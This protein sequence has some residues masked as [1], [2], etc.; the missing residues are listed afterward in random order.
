MNVINEFEAA[1]QKFAIEAPELES[2][3]IRLQIQRYCVLLWHKNQ[4]LNLTRHC[5]WET[6]VSRDLVDTLQ[7]SRLIP[8]DQE[9][10]DIGSGGGVPGLLLAILR[11][12]VEVS[13][14]ESTGKKAHALTEFAEALS[15]N[16]LIYAD[17]A[18]KLLLDFRFDVSTA[19]AVGP[20]SKLCQ[21]FEDR[22]PHLGRLLAIKGPGWVEEERQA[23]D[24]GLLAGVDL[25][26]AAEYEPPEAG[27]KSTILELRA[28]RA[29]T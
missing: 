23:R 4:E 25:T 9:V 18:E 27:W 5:D 13:L 3:S 17:R 8:A 29:P 11:P 22:W 26:V 12:D 16:V 19:R 10:L 15:L 20:L 1:V 14:A 2:E 7:L 28:K 6:F 21:L 24:A